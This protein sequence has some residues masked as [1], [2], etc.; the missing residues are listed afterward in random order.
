MLSSTSPSEPLRFRSRAC[1]RPIP[2]NSIKEKRRGPSRAKHRVGRLP[3]ALQSIRYPPSP[4][5]L[6]SLRKPHVQPERCPSPRR[7]ALYYAI[8]HARTVTEAASYVA[9]NEEAVRQ[10]KPRRIARAFWGVRVFVR[11]VKSNHHVRMTTSD[12][13][14]PQWQSLLIY[15]LILQC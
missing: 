9:K 12:A 5:A 3:R 6:P 4:A 14:V 15:F 11:E 13:H 10:Q 7:H 8:Q 2:C 1:P